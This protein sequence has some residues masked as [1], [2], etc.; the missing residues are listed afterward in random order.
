MCACVPNKVSV[1]VMAYFSTSVAWKYAMAIVNFVVVDL[2]LTGHCNDW[3][4]TDDDREKREWQQNC[5]SA[6]SG[7]I[8]ADSGQT[9]D[10]D[11]EEDDDDD[12]SG[13]NGSATAQS[14]T[15]YSLSLTYQHFPSPFISFYFPCRVG[16]LF[17]QL[18][19]WHQQ[20]VLIK[21]KSSMKQT[22]VAW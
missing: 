20:Q 19:H 2:L 11:E 1:W 13:G 6:D 15:C 17:C 10:E 7:K 3:V 9:A 8:S 21:S 4:S 12:G 22:A 18:L 14:S 5:W 16:Q